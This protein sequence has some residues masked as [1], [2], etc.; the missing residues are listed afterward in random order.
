V[1]LRD[2]DA[3]LTNPALI[4]GGQQQCTLTQLHM[5]GYAAPHVDVGREACFYSMTAGLR[6]R[7]MSMSTMKIKVNKKIRREDTIISALR[8]IPLLV[9]YGSLDVHV[10]VATHY[11]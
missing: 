9:L 11:C 5:L 4:Y 6:S 1:N 10:H 7:R 3:S 2:V 8:N